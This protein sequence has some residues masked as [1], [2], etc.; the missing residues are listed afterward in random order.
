M[1]SGGNVC[2]KSVGW[3]IYTRVD[4]TDGVERVRRV[5]S[6]LLRQGVV[7]SKMGSKPH[8]AFDPVNIIQYHVDSDATGIYVSCGSSVHHCSTYSFKQV[9]LDSQHG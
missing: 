3:P 9:R 2:R 6:F 4:D 8:G 5:D 1:I 7:V